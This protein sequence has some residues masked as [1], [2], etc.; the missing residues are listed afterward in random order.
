MKK[1]LLLLAL[2]FNSVPILY[3]QAG[4]LDPSFGE[5]GIVHA[6]FGSKEN[7]YGAR[8]N[9]VFTDSNGTTYLIFETNEQS[10]IIHFL[11][12]GFLTS[13]LEKP[14]ALCK[15]MEKS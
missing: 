15:M 7:I 5:N 9:Q 11:P 12:D 14:G 4:K 10:S 6:D 2:A 13:L 3:S 8:G 1:L